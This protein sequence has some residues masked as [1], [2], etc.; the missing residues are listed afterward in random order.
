MVVPQI[1]FLVETADLLKD[2]WQKTGVQL[3]I[4]TMAV[5]DINKEILRTR[6]YQML[7]FGNI[8]NNNP[9]VFAF[10]HSSE[11]FY[12]GL[13][14]SSYNSREADRLLEKI[15]QEINPEQR[16]ADMSRLQSIINQDT[17]A[18]FLFN[19]NYIYIAPNNLYGFNLSFAAT[20]ANRFDKISQWHLKIG[21][22]FAK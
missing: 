5:D 1:P 12:P 3:N 4:V 10:W 6:N 19:P 16:K 15:R 9:D 21:R 2:D 11:R 18:I 8:L 7:L 14:L 20:T 13:N 17:P 22:Q